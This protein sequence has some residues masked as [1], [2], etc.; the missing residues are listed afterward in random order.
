M[1]TWKIVAV[2]LAAID[3]LI[4]W[5]ACRNGSR[6]DNC[7]R[8]ETISDQIARLELEPG[9]QTL[10]VRA[11]QSVQVVDAKGSSYGL[12]IGPATVIIIKRHE[13]AEPVSELI[14]A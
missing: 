3:V 9:I 1:E 5:A 11:D 8:R 4:I 13:Q 12:E 14:G 2:I 10:E 6:Y 7:L